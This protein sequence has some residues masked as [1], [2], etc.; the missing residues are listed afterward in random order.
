MVSSTTKSAFWRGFRDAAPFFLVVA[1]FGLL[2]GVVAIEAGLTLAQA[3]GMSSLVIAGAA[4]FSAL[5]LMTENAPIA[6]VVAAAVAVNLRMAMY[7]AAL[8]PHLGPS[9]LWQRALMSYVLFDQTF[10]ASS[11]EFERNPDQSHVA[12]AAYFAG[13]VMPVAPVWLVFS[14]IGALV[15]TGIPPELGL[16]FA[17]P[18][19]FLAIVAP[20][21][22]T[23]AHV[24]AAFTSALLALALA[25]LPSGIGLLIAGGVAMVVGAVVEVLDAKDPSP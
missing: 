11:L 20:M 12:K 2:F 25:G 22:R 18:I 9:P 15:G 8:A 21:L 16:D 1:P 3:M 7:S 6:L 17:V 19:T 4:Q 23:R 14:L 5:Q 10:A 13:T 24:A